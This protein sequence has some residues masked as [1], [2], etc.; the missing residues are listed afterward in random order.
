MRRLELKKNLLFVMIL[1]LA[2]LAACAPGGA[3]LAG[4]SWKLVSYGPVSGQKTAVAGVETS[5]VFRTDGKVSGK[6]GC[7]SMG[8]D[9]SARDAQIT[10]GEI[11]STMMACPDP[12]MEQEGA[13]FD[14]LKNTAG[15]KLEGGRLTITSTDGKNALV[16]A[17]VK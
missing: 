15:F 14:V 8:G 13:A 2:M 6:L 17:A 12:Q 1:C 4:T 10:F 3:A 9:Y 7:N 11:V 16:F 5:L